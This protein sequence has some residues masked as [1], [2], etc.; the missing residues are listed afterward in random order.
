VTT[1]VTGIYF[2]MNGMQS[3]L[4]LP[5]QLLLQLKVNEVMSPTVKFAVFANFYSMKIIS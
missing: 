3:M 5:Q 4:L 1:A 2:S